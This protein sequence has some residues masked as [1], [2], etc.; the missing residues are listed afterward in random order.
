MS[1]SDLRNSQRGGKATSADEPVTM[2]EPMPKEVRQALDLAGEPGENGTIIAIATDLRLDNAYGEEWL[3]V[4]HD[5]LCVLDGANGQWHFRIDAPLE[6]LRNPHLEELVGG[7][8]LRADIDG[9][10][11]HLVMTTNARDRQLGRAAKYLED[12][13][14]YHAAHAMGE[15]AWTR[16]QGEK[17]H[18]GTWPP[19]GPRL[20]PDT[21][22]RRRCPTCN[23]LLRRGTQVCPACINKTRVLKRIFSY[24]K[25]YKKKTLAVW[26]LMF[27]GVGL[28]LLEPYLVKPLVDTVLAS[29]SA[30]SADRR[31]KLLGLFV[32]LM[33]GAAALG[34]GVGILRGRL[35]AWLG[36]RVSHDLRAQVHRYV[37][38]Q[39]LKFFDKRDTGNLMARV[40]RDTE[41]LERVITRGMQFFVFHIL[42]L[43]GIGIV[44]FV[45]NWRLALL[46][47]L[48]APIV[49]VISRFLWKK[50]HRMFHRHWHARARCNALLADTLS[51]MRVVKA[52]AQEPK[53]ID[54]FADRSDKY[55]N[56]AMTVGRYWATV[57]P[58]IWMLMGLGI[59]I[60]W[61]VGGREV[62]V[63][64]DAMEVGTLL[65]F[66]AFIA[67]FYQPLQGLS[68]MS[69]WFARSLSSAERVFEI[70][71]SERDVDDI[72]DAIKLPEIKGHV[73]FRDV[74][75]GYDA[76]KPV[77]KNITLDV[78]PGE[79]IGLVGHS[80]AGKSTMINL[81]CRFYDPQQGCVLIDGEDIRD[82]HQQDL[83]RQLGVVL[84]DTF[85]FNGTIAENIC[86]A[87]DAVTFEEIM[88]AA[89]AANAHDF[90][91]AKPDGYD[92]IVGERGAKLSGGERQRIAI[93]RAILHDPRILILDEATSSVDADTEHQIQQAVARLVEGRTTFAI[94]HRLS[95]LR[96]AD[97]LIVLKDGEIAEIG[98]HEELMDAKGEFHRLV[99]I[100]A[101]SSRIMAING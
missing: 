29:D 72:E 7:V 11:V 12:A 47:L 63:N 32:G 10:P 9:H 74:T 46:V 41:S 76:H 8:A 75:F 17:P 91:V 81:L 60:V 59:Y 6:S 25:P 96:N 61:F 13:A 62:V 70:L 43:V 52:F 19:E 30:L 92:T 85:L 26:A 86:Y 49:T 22:E 53:E 15:E 5:R 44:L 42:L 97:R 55:F 94:A 16:R 24:L 79:M 51:G 27:A 101:E 34:H 68:Q 50:L 2:I 33:F 21:E 66:V 48:P 80:G 38:L 37:Q 83:R 23:L 90:I 40:M 45:L 64:P 95:T 87:K 84:Q 14:N 35:V 4:T 31:L 1:A 88:A 71:D 65:A 20:E 78:K 89:K 98:T 39:S 56:A 18:A 54:R 36:T 57:F 82:I 100:Q 3:V 73:E 69:E 28:S 93:A 99:S 67:R 77:L 58:I